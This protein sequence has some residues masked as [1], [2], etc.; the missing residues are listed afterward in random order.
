MPLPSYLPRPQ[1]TLGGSDQDC[2]DDRTTSIVS[3]RLKAKEHMENHAMKEW[4]EIS[5]ATQ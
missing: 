2:R 5:T 4:K 3:L 1:G